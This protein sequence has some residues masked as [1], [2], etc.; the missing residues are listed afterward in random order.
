MRKDDTTK[1]PIRI[2]QRDIERYEEMAKYESKLREDG[3]SLIAGVDEAGRG[4]LAGPVVAAAC[5]L[6]ANETFYGLNDSK[7]MTEKRREA[8]FFDIRQRAVAW[9]IA[10]ASNDEI[11]RVNILEATKAAMREA[12]YNLPVKPDIA[13]I[14]AVALKGLDYPVMVEKRG[15]ARINAIAAASVLAKVTRDNM[16]KSWDT[17]YPAYRFS[18]HKGYG[19][20]E[21]MDTIRSHGPC[22]IHRVSFLGNI[23][24][25]TSGVYFD[26]GK[27][28]EY[29]VAEDLIAKNHTILE[30]R[31]AIHQV[32]EID[33]ITCRDGELYVIE[34]KGRDS[35]SSAFGGADEMLL[36]NQVERIRIVASK[37]LEEH[38]QLDVTVEMMFAA[39]DTDCSG[40]VMNI[41]YIPFM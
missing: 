33:F 10:M 35:F 41:R 40:D 37:W 24:K 18:S 11:D 4:P 14:D 5:I 20:K 27:H 22:P 13:V 7:K 15:D 21:H 1:R 36:D 39:V 32:G 38:N 28:V 9:S 8:L 3:F 31:Y 16:M 30:H 12:L 25:D 19:T 6:P 34:C 2:S 29:K 23:L 17:V 26:R